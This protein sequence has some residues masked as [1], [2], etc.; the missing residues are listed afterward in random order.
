[1]VIRAPSC[2]TA[3]VRHELIAPP[4][5]EHGAGAALALIAA[6]F[7]PGEVD[8]IAKRIEQGCPWGEPELPFNAI[9]D[10]CHRKLIGHGYGLPGRSSRFAG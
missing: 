9:Y 8:M 2:M 1:M 3:N 6:F 7:R 5:N 10:Q 4:V